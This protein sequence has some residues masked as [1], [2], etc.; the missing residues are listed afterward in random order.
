L[1]AK[2]DSANP[3]PRGVRKCAKCRKK[4]TARLGSILEDSK[5]LYS[6]FVM[7]VHLMTS[8]KKGI[9]SHQ[10]ARETGITQ[11]SAWF[12]CH[13]IREAM[14]REPLAG[15]LRGVVEVDECYI[16]GKPRRGAGSAK[17][18][19]STERKTPVMVLV[20]RDGPARVMPLENVTSASLKGEVKKYVSTDATVMTDEYNSYTGLA[21]VFAGHETVCHSA[22]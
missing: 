19:R 22:G 3:T 16:G 4:F 14:K 7:A 9:S 17:R 1:T 15:M 13:R 10:I 12:L 20:E 5:I 2:P 6:K 18:G 11:K 21:E 8:S